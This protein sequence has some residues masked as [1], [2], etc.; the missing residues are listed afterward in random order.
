[1]FVPSLV[2]EVGLVA[3][4]EVVLVVTLVAEVGG[5]TWAVVAVDE[6][7]ADLGGEE[8]VA[9]SGD[10]VVNTTWNITPPL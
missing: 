5:V 1:M 7:V 8:E 2:E 4:G 3:E 10:A 6:E 9:D